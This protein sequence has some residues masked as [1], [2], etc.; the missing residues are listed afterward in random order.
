MI[1]FNH[2]WTPARIKELRSAYGETQKVFCERLGIGYST[3]FHIEQGIC[4][5]RRGLALLLD[6][7]QEDMDAVSR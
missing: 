6:R 2:D 3:V 1:P 4:P 5:V 7:I